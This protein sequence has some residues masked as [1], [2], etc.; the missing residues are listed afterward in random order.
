L[1][2]K[3]KIQEAYEDSMKALS[4]L[5]DSG[6]AHAHAAQALRF[7]GRLEEAL[8]NYS[9]A[10]V[11]AGTNVPGLFYERGS[12]LNDQNRPVE[13]QRD[14]DQAIVLGYSNE[15]VRY[16]K[17][18]SFLKENVITNAIIELSAA[19]AMRSDMADA[20]LARGLAY[21]AG[22]QFGMADRDLKEAIR[23]RPSLE[24]ALKPK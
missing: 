22:G 10:I 17:G 21:A 16:G 20:Y 18:V 11:L 15:W 8:T 9:R 24:A 13:A 7:L 2:R 1:L 23:L 4:L 19:I 5:P 12:L 14:F 3:G 6:L